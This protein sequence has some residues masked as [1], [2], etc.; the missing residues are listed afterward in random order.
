[1]SPLEAESIL[2]ESLACVTHDPPCTS[3]ELRIFFNRG[4]AQAPSFALETA[5]FGVTQVRAGLGKP[6]VYLLDIDSDGDQ[7]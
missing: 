7:A 6:L 1:M 3:G 4:T 2:Y 5:D